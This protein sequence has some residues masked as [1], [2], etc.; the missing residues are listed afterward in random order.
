MH[1]GDA[2]HTQDINVNV[3][4]APGAWL[5]ENSKRIDGL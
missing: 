1:S 4:H 3:K 5:K 2:N